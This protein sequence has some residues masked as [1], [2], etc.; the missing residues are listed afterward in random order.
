[1]RPT[2]KR[3]LLEQLA[4]KGP[5]R[6]TR[7]WTALA[8]IAIATIVLVHF[9]GSTEGAQRPARTEHPV[10]KAP[11][12]GVFALPF[13]Q[14]GGNA[15]VAPAAAEAGPIEE[16]R[17]TFR[18]TDDLQALY[19]Q[20]RDRPEVDARYLAFR[21]ARDCELLRT[22]AI[23]VELDAL[24]ERRGERERQ[25]T[26]A[27]A[28]CRGFQARPAPRDDMLRLEQEAAAAGSLPAQVALAADTFSQRPVPDAI[29]V[30]RRALASGDQLAFDESRVLLAMSRHQVEIGGVPPF[31]PG[32]A[33]SSDPRVV[34]VDLVGCRLGNPCGQS[35][36]SISI[37]CGSNLSC[38]RDAEEW[39][40][41][42]ASLDDDEQRATQALAA[43]MLVAFRRGAIDEIVRIPANAQAQ[44]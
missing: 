21:A 37:D 25:A 20:W 12:E 4:R 17:Q 13:G 11:F 7:L 32:D 31:A 42:M 40:M 35:R 3:A 36:G 16:L 15:A 23:V 34:A 10:A 22:G 29:A 28:R 14:A 8:L 39:L 9:L 18:R 5:P 6:G 24:S 41:Q 19:L 44:R 43:R 30:V 33:R 2:S 38:L 26:L 27:T 1:M